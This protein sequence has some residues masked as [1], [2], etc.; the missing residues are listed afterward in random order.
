V[1]ESQERKANGKERKGHGKARQGN[2]GR[3]RLKE[4]EGGRVKEG[5]LMERKGKG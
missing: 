3:T 1:R 4:R 5:R 2:E